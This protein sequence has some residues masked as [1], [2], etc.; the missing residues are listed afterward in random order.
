MPFGSFCMNWEFR[1]GINSSTNLQCKYT[2][3][4]IH[5]MDT[6]NS[7]RSICIYACMWVHTAALCGISNHSSD[8]RGKKLLADIKPIKS[9]VSGERAALQHTS[10]LFTDE[11]VACWILMCVSVLVNNQSNQQ[12]KGGADRHWRS[13]NVSP[14]RVSARPEGLLTWCPF[15]V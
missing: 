14:K 2:R 7:R 5:V 10:K 1:I 11:C 3:V 15:K 8:W 4:N 9:P 12:K 13:V 6:S